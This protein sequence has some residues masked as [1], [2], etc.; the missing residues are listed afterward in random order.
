MQALELRIPPP[1]V[2]LAVAVVMW[3]ISKATPSSKCP[4]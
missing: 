2:A 3:G 4:A 1:I